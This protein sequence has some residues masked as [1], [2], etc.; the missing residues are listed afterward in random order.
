MIPWCEHEPKILN[1]WF[2]SEIRTK[3]ENIRYTGQCEERSDEAIPRSAQTPPQA[4]PGDC[5]ASLAM[6]EVFGF[7]YK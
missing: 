2:K 5:F 3:H 1:F 4:R 6:T 7:I